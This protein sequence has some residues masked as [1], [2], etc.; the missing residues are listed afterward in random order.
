[1]NLN[2]VTSLLNDLAPLNH[3]ADWD[4]VGLLISSKNI[5]INNILLTIDLTNDVLK[6]AIKKRT[7]LIISYHPFLFNPL[8]KINYNNK[9]NQILSNLF[10]ND[11]AVYSP[12]TALDNIENG[13]NNWL[14]KSLGEGK[15]ENIFL[16]NSSFSCGK[17]V[18]LEKAINISIISKK[19]K[20]Y[21]NV[22]YL[23]VA[24]VSNKKIKTIAFCAGSGSDILKDI[25]A[26]CYV[27]GEMSHHN[28]LS[29]NFKGT[30]V[31]LSE[32]THTERG[33][34]KIYK[35]M[36]NNVLESSIK[37]YISKFDRDPIKLI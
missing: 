28:I 34:L 20:N 29:A 23:R 1:M 15:I 21:L 36:I 31:I 32:H 13:I 18:T 6:E 8:K 35:K 10:K 33:F 25:N 27:T 9:K 11:I 3:A 16:P 5:K 24:A 2:K 19:I 14:S 26:D 22:K 12:H 30:H 7:N 37:V 17:L 4:N